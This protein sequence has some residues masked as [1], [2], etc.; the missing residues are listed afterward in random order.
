MSKRWVAIGVALLLLVSVPGSVAGINVSSAAETAASPPPTTSNS[1]E[2][3]DPQPTSH[4]A[5]FTVIPQADGEKIP[6]RTNR[7]PAFTGDSVSFQ[8]EPA[9]GYAFVNATWETVG[10][11]TIENVSADPKT[12]TTAFETTAETILTVTVTLRNVETNSTIERTS[13][14]YTLISTSE[15][16]NIDQFSVSF[17]ESPD[18]WTEAA[19]AAHLRDLPTLHANLSQRIPLPEQVDLV[20]TTRD[21]I[22]TQCAQFA[23][24]C[25]DVSGSDA[26]MYMPYDA[27]NYTLEQ[28]ASVYRHELTHVAQFERMEMT[29]DSNWDFIV[30]GHAEYEETPRYG[31]RTLEEKP[32][33]QELFEFTGEDYG[34]AELFVSAFVAAYDYQALEEIIAISEYNSLDQAFQRVVDES[35]TSFYERWTPTNASAGPNAVRTIYPSSP[36]T[37]QIH[38]KPRFVY[39]DSTLTARGFGPYA[40]GDGVTVSWDTDSDG[41]SE[42]T[43]QTANWTPAE[44]GE[45]TVTLSYTNGN[46]SLSRTQTVTVSEVPLTPQDVNGDGLYEDVNGDGAVTITDVQALFANRDD[47]VVQNNPTQFDFNGDGQFTVVD[48]Q[49]LFRQVT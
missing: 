11:A 31:Q 27:G 15:N 45:Y 30:E 5:T 47:A 28:R 22:Q 40:S 3:P 21:A 48:V 2:P 10:P 20:Y 4:A 41:Q 43:G 25:V 33:Q 9:E 8:I 24:A 14:R 38:Q 6:W 23:Y 36:G 18:R 13:P 42:L 12:A 35:F 17:A 1:P 44:T 29:F 19:I 37:D 49:A 16:Q 39:R 26:T 34:E 7:L 32:S 46:A